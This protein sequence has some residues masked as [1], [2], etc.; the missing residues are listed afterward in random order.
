MTPKLMTVL[1]AAIVPDCDRNR[2]SRGDEDQN[3]AGLNRIDFIRL[4]VEDCIG[5]FR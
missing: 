3:E 5:L 2:C 4:R 1:K